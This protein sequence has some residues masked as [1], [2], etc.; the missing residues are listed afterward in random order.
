MGLASRIPAVILLG[1]LLLLAGETHAES[2]YAYGFHSW[3][4]GADLLV[5]NGKTGWYV[6][7]PTVDNFGVRD[8]LERACGEGFTTIVGFS[9]AGGQGLPRE[10]EEWVQFS[11][12]CAKFAYHLRGVCHIFH[13]GN[14]MDLGG[15]HEVGY[16]TDCFR[17]VYDAVKSLRPDAV[18]CVGPPIGLGYF[19]EMS[20]RLGDVPDG[21]QGHVHVPQQ[22]FWH[23]QEIPGA[24][25]KPMYVTEFTR[26]PY[27]EGAAPNFF[28]GTEDW[29]A[30]NPDQQLACGC[31]FLYDSGGW[32]GFRLVDIPQAVAD[33]SQ[34]TATTSVTNQYAARFISGSGV[35]IEVLDEASVRVSWG[36]DVASTTQLSWY[37]DGATRS[38]SDALQSALGHAHLAE[39]SGLSPWE[40]YTLWARS[41]A[42]GYGDLAAGPYRF[43]TA[44]SSMDAAGGWNLL[45]VPL[46]MPE[47][48]AAE[49]LGGMDAGSLAGNLYRY[50]PGIGYELYPGGF[51]ELER[52]R[53]YWLRLDDARELSMT[54]AYASGMQEIALS[55]GWNLIGHPLEVSVPLSLVQVSDGSQT[56]SLAEAGS[57]GW[58]QAALYSYDSGYAAVAPSS[59]VLQPWAGYWLLAYLDDLT[60]LVARP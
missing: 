31:W 57:A 10:K 6:T 40:L 48:E 45:S 38:A 22:F 29:N 8:E 12:D 7:Y 3:T 44:G 11:R 33:W 36:T 14:E 53:G 16:F 34:M 13:L 37:P 46:L 2:M 30:A 39:A 43:G 41:T 9:F 26:I 60:L 20:D 51:T 52:G 49:V 4:D 18:F 21:Y 47:A 35:S 19:E 1:G 25:R 5:M 24:R 23:M 15:G 56:L 55:S 50:G 28:S 32:D 27:Y 42:A 59:G 17:M 54:G 58:L